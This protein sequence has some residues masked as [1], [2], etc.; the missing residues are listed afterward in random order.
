MMS[1]I[2]YTTALSTSRHG[3][4]QNAFAS[5]PRETR[6]AN[7]SSSLGAFNRLAEVELSVHLR[8]WA[9]VL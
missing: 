5:P 2:G 6:N 9:D 1:G 4:D 7:R 8:S 3:A